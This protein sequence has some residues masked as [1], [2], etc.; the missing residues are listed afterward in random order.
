M[1]KLKLA[2]LS[3]AISVAGPALA[4]VN[5]E[6]NPQNWR[7][8]NYVPGMVNIYYSGSSCLNGMLTFPRD[9]PDADKNRFWSLVLTAKSTGK[10]IGIY[11]ETINGRCNITSYY[12]I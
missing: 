10:S 2:L 3:A 11:Y 7:L 1:K 12:S 9:A 6:G 4:D 5:I 8:Q